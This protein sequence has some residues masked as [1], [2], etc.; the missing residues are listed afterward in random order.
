M[1]VRDFGS[2]LLQ[3]KMLVFVSH[4]APRKKKDVTKYE[5][6]T[7]AGKRSVK[8]FN[9]HKVFDCEIEA[10]ESFGIR[11][12]KKDVRLIP[13]DE[14][15]IEFTL[16][17][18]EWA[19][20]S[21]RCVGYKGKKIDGK[22][23]V[24]GTHGKEVSGAPPRPKEDVP[25]PPKTPYAPNFPE[26]LK[27]TKLIRDLDICVGIKRAQYLLA[28]RAFGDE[29]I[30]YYDVSDA[31]SSY[32]RKKKLK[33]SSAPQFYKELEKLVESKSRNEVDAEVGAVSYKDQKL[34]VLSCLKV[35]K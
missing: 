16:T 8:L 12:T 4:S 3:I 27:L 32:L 5:W 19:A 9:H 20:I 35:V 21:K 24:S 7:F 25:K 2:S 26:D 11:A 31:L 14:L 22:K 13:D 10:G 29:V 1:G 33:Q 6:Y 28:N 30:Y 15:T 23:V 17:F 18:K 34:T